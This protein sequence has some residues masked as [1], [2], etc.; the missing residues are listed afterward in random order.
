MSASNC[1]P[2][3]SR[4]PLCTHYTWINLNGGTC[5]LKQGNV[6]RQDAFYVNDPTRICGIQ[7]YSNGTIVNQTINWNGNNWANACEFVGNDLSNVLSTAENCGRLCANTSL[8]THFTWTTFNGGTCYMKQ[9]S[10]TKQDA[11]STNNSTMICG[12]VGSA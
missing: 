9:G 12:I 4:T 8:C 11:V 2:T 1:G 7:S 5:F 6:S 10:V 3:C